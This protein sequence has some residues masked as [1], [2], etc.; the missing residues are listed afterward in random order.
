MNMPIS[1]YIAGPLTT[2]NR[3]AVL[4]TAVA[5]S[6]KLLDRGYIVFCPHTMTSALHKYKERSYSE[7]MRVCFYWLMRCDVVFR[8]QGESKG[9]D[10]EVALAGLLGIPAV[11]DILELESLKQDAY[12]ARNI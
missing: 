2:G 10:S 6:S 4:E 3:Q 9:A 5:I 11:S 1:V 7:W 12:R 8:L